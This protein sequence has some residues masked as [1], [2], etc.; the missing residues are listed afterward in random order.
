[1][2]DTLSRISTLLVAKYKVDA[3]RIRL[4]ATMADI[5]LDSLS[6]AELLFDL[7]DEF[8]IEIK[9]DHLDLKKL[10]DAVQLVDNLVAAKAV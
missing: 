10:A 9:M 5:G 6:L 8:K 3:S 1:M 2:Q 7:E 4:D